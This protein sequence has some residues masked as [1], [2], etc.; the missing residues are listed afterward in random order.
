MKKYH[1]DK[2][3]WVLSAWID[4]WLAP[5]FTDWNLDDALRGIRC[6]V[7][8]IHGE[9]DEYGS[10]LHPQ[11]I[12]ALTSGLASLEIL[13]YGHVPHREQSEVVIDMVSKWLNHNDGGAHR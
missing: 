10:V 11:R 9:S 2:A 8:A 4:T 7:L 1:G 5:S 3:A 6:P 12:A 13:P